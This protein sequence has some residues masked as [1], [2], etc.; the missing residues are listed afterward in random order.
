MQKT[1][2]LADFITAN[3]ILD[4]RVKQSILE[5]FPESERL[6]SVLDVLVN[7][8]FV[9]KLEDEI[10]QKAKMRIDENQ[11][12]YFLRE[13]KRA[14]EEELGEDDSPIDD[15]ENYVDKIEKLNLDEN[16]PTFFIKN[17]RNSAKCLMAVRKRL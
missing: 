7:E 1:G 3:L 2:E 13:Q 5:T 10:S 9:L 16:L 14:I 17:V 6:E 12:D 11:R 8:N 15:A 4:Y